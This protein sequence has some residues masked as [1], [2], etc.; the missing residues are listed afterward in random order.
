LPSLQ[1]IQTLDQ[2]KGAPPD[3]TVAHVA[4]TLVDSAQTVIERRFRILLLIRDA[5]D[6]LASDAPALQSVL[7]DLSAML[8]LL[9]AWAT[10]SYR[11][12]PW[13]S[14]MMV[15]GAVGYFVLPFD[16]IPDVLGPI[17]LMDDAAI[18]ASTVR[19]IRAELDRFRQWESSGALNTGTGP[20]VAGANEKPDR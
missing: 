7:S 18:I 5:Y 9:Y 11:R 3:L 19:S 15:A 2:A 16:L 8:R 4:D 6:R 1:R 20:D 12:I 13:P 14:V 10:A 17:G